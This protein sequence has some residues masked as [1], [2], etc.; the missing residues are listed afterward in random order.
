[1]YV[2]GT[3]AIAKIFDLR[4]NLTLYRAMGRRDGRQRIKKNKTKKT[5][6]RE[7][8]LRKMYRTNRWLFFS[9][10]KKYKILLVYYFILAR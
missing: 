5:C 10:K 7:N 6:T 9:E 1:M 2:H 8:D 4:F 3:I